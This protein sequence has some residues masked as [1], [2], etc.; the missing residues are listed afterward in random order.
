MSHHTNT[1]NPQVFTIP[2][3]TDFQRALAGGMLTQ[4]QADS[5]PFALHDNI[6]LT[7]TRRAVR[8]LGDAFLQLKPQNKA[9]LLPQIL[10]IGDVDADEP[11][12]LSGKLPLQIPPEIASNR[13]L[14]CLAE[15]VQHRAKVSGAPVSLP[16]ALAE[17]QAIASLLDTAAHEG[18]TDFTLATAEFSDF[19]ATQPGHV[20]NA[21]RFLEIIN[22]Y[23]PAFLAEQGL[24]DAAT[25]RVKMLE[26]LAD[27]WR[28]NPT[29]KRVIAAGSTG[30]QKAT[31]NLLKVIANLP[32]GCVVLPGLDLELDERAWE[33]I[34]SS[35]GHPQFGMYHLLQVLGVSRGE[36]KI[37]PQIN[38][39]QQQ[40]RRR[41]IINEA[42]TPAART[43]DWLQRLQQ[44]GKTHAMPVAEL[45]QDALQGLS[46]IE[47]DTEDEEALVLALAIRHTLEDKQKTAMLVTPDRALAR[48]VRA[49]LQ[50]WEIEVDDSAG[51]V[52][53]EEQTGVFLGLVL[54]WWLDPGEPVALLALL[55]HPLSCIGQA[56]GH[57]QNL[58]KALDIGFLR[59]VR[60]H[61]NLDQLA[62]KINASKH[63]QKQQLGA[64]IQT[65]HGLFDALAATEQSVAVLATCHVQLAEQLAATD[66]LAGAQNLWRGKGGEMASHLFRSLLEDS[67]PAGTT[68]L[69]GYQQIYEFFAGNI[70][71]RPTQPKGG[72]VRILGPLEARQQSAD[73][74]LLGGL[75]EGV[76]PSAVRNDP[77]LPRSLL[78]RLQL[79]DPE[80]RLGLSAHDFAE[81]ACKP[82]VLL[83]RAARRGGTPG[84]ASR[85]L[86]RLQTLCKAAAGQNAPELLRCKPDYLAHARQLRA[87]ENLHPAPQPRPTPPVHLRPKGLSVTQIKTLIRNP[88]A[89]YGKKIL[90]LIALDQIA[91]QPG[92]LERGNA[93]HHALEDWH[94]QRQSG[95]M[96]AQQARLS[97]MIESKLLAAG[98]DLADMA[99][100]APAARRIADAYLVWQEEREA[101]GITVA[102]IE[103]KGSLLLDGWLTISAKTDRLDRAGNIWSVLDYKTGIPASTA[104]VFAG[105]DPQLPLTAAI[106]QGGGF[107]GIGKAAEVEHLLYLQLSGGKKPLTERSLKASKDSI[108]QSIAELIELEQK[109]V[110]ELFREFEKPQTPYLCQPRAKYTDSYSDYDLLARRAEWS[111]ILSD[112]P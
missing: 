28:Q 108:V 25:R 30:S 33:Q 69:A 46:L 8:T 17:A 19:L 58:A 62:E 110:L 18:V 95:D 26:A 55:A 52:L 98:F 44:L 97:E 20:Q 6:V 5:S 84:I 77:F 16:S 65:L 48:R 23:W 103:Q 11:P 93:I 101:M 14:F 3:G 1:I 105:F 36:V 31:A 96:A 94:Q 54:N 80:R 74:V 68:D 10:P 83:S 47:A 40:A 70:S 106:L 90:R 71:V 109:R 92:P 42:M 12:F 41:R 79:P 13:R 72:R 86:W 24:I 82:N 89:I 61:K 66:E 22:T 32:N 9:T 7:P 73:L 76:W 51:I 15:I 21:A 107:D 88:Y 99:V 60:R 29:D 34:A 27:E 87:V 50:F 38:I 39:N 43:S 4:S 45:M 35:P 2:S 57:V 59:G 63:G 85:W 49:A 100:E 91:R 75:D 111:A 102:K 104:E 64:L 78:T 67:S 37:W 53:P 112:A 56:K 81:N